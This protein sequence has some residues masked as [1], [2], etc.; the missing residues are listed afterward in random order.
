[1]NLVLAKILMNI[2]LHKSGGNDKVQ[3]YFIIIPVP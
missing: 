1:L 3:L 2:D